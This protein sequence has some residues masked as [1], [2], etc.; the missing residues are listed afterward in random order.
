MS[1]NY[2]NNADFSITIDAPVTSWT[3]TMTGDSI[4]SKMI[5]KLSKIDGLEDIDNIFITPTLSKDY[6][7][8]SEIT[9]NL[10]FDVRR[11]DGEIKL[12]SVGKSSNGR[13]KSIFDF[14]GTMSSDDSMFDVS[15]KFE[16]AISG[17]CNTD[18]NGDP[19]IKLIANKEKNPTL[20]VVEINA[21]SFFNM[22]MNISDPTRYEYTIVSVTPIG[23]NNF[24]YEI[25]KRLLPA[26]RS[27]KRYGNEGDKIAKRL[28]AEQN[29]GGG[30]RRQYR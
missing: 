22:V 3:Y 14:Q 16:Q 15:K 8:A 1:T 19:I 27:G 21:D 10:A 26:K 17:L 29:H 20:A 4:S 2:N 9:V 25:S 18:R 23:N 6:I 30:S 13:K 28:Y 12:R 11:P 5:D 7:G 24:V